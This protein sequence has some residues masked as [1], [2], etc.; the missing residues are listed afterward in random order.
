MKILQVTPGYYPV[1]GGV[2]KH[3]QALAERLAAAGHQVTVAT[4]QAQGAQGSGAEAD[5]THNGVAIHRFPAIGFGDAYRVPPGL[6]RY[7]KGNRNQ[8]DIVHVHNYHAALI[9]L[10]ALVD[11]LAPE[12]KPLVVTTHLND[13]PHSAIARLLHVPYALIGRWAV[14]QA[15]AVI[16]VTQAERERTMSRLAVPP[17]RSVVIPN[18]VSASLVA[19]R[20]AAGERDRHLLL[21]VGRLQAYKR[22]EDAVAALALL[23]AP[24]RLVVVGDGPQRAALEQ[25]ARD[26]GVANRVEFVGRTSDAGLIE[27]YRRAGVVVTLSEAEAFGMTVLEGVAAGAPVVCSDI[28]AFRDLAAQFAGHVSVVPRRDPRAAAAAVR[29]AA[30]RATGAP[31]DISAF[32]WDAVVDRVLQLYRRVTAIVETTDAHGDHLLSE[33]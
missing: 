9:P 33:G 13:T 32:T 27:W 18:G 3:V 8:W 16:C 28:P 25:Q 11:V 14:N 24:Y 1:I 20:S 6:L 22:V 2:E 21:A 5:E 31:A 19:A 12:R 29:L 4:M 23:E 17:E 15:D 26:S 7:L 10:V 30:E